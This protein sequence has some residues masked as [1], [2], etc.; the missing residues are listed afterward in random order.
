MSSTAKSVAI[1]AA[2]LCLVAVVSC[3][4]SPAAAPTS[5]TPAP[6]PSQLMPGNQ[7][8]GVIAALSGDALVVTLNQGGTARV[9]LTSSTVVTLPSGQSGA[10]SDL[11]AGA[12]VTV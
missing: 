7:I 4:A 1:L 2:G 9:E 3:T 8:Q 5:S 10:R 11:T 6:P 12:V